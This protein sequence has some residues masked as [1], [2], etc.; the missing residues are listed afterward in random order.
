MK[1]SP[2]LHRS[3]LAISEAGFL[4]WRNNTGL[5]WVGKPIRASVPTAVTLMPG[6][7]LIRKARP[8][9]AGLGV[10]GSD[11]I[12]IG[13]DGRFAGVE[14][15]SDTGQQSDDQKNWGRC[16]LSRGGLYGVA[17]SEDEAVSVFRGDVKIV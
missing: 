12:G 9:H 16:V 14:T 10:G 6:D 8:L 2:V 4:C 7:V 5:A 13:T 3:L 17:R 11:I 1:E 15:K